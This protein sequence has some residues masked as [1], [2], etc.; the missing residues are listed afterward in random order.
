M[1]LSGWGSELPHKE[2]NKNEKNPNPTFRFQRIRK[3]KKS[4]K[5]YIKNVCKK[6]I[7]NKN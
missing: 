3:N 7:T 2:D 5:N 1:V 6:T 4:K